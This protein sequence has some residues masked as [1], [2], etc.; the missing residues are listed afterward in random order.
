[1]ARCAECGRPA[2]E[3]HPFIGPL[4]EEDAAIEAD[5]DARMDRKRELDEQYRRECEAELHEEYRRDCD[6]QRRKDLA[7][8]LE[9]KG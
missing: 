5:I 6:E 1:M 8:E 9:G 4:C 2:C 3:D 7:A